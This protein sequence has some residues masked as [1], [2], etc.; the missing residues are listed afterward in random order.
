MNP[1]SHSSSLTTFTHVHSR[2][3]L[4]LD[5]WVKTEHNGV[6]LTGRVLAVTPDPGKAALYEVELPPQAGLYA[7]TRV[8]RHAA[9]LRSIEGEQLPG[10]SRPQPWQ[11]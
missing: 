9:E 1:S 3:L 7:L 11:N 8:L 2:S 4:Y 5:Q 6:A 10:L